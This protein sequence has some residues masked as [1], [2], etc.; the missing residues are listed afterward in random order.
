[1]AYQSQIDH[2]ICPPTHPKQI[3]HIFIEVNHGVI[4]VPDQNSGGRFVF[5]QGDPTGYGFHADF[6]NGWDMDIQT[7]AVKNCLNTV[8]FGQISACPPLYAT[9]T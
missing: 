5:S 4:N 1:V 8:D 9:D 7:Y 3:P 6:Q 2:G